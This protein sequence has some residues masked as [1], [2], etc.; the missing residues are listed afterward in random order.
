MTTKVY[1]VAEEEQIKVSGLLS[2]IFK[3]WGYEVSA[4][5]NYHGAL[6]VTPSDALILVVNDPDNRVFWAVAE[7]Y[8]NKTNPVVILV[9][10]VSNFVPKRLIPSNFTIFETSPGGPDLR[11]VLDSLRPR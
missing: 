10:N 11:N 3:M 9:N 5:P 4:H 1:I 8:E 6:G 2:A 7:V